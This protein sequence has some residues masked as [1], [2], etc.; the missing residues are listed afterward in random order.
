MT[1]TRSLAPLAVAVVAIFGG[2][3][4]ADGGTSTVMFQWENYKYPD[5]CLGVGLVEQGQANFVV[6]AVPIPTFTVGRWTYADGSALGH[7]EAPFNTA[8]FRVGSNRIQFQAFNSGGTPWC[9]HNQNNVWLSGLTPQRK[10]LFQVLLDGDDV[11]TEVQLQ[12]SLADIDPDL[13]AKIAAF[14][15]SILDK[16]AEL[17]KLG[18]DAD[19]ASA[20]IARLEALLAALDELLTRGFDQ[21]SVAELDALLADFE[22]LLPGLRDD[23]AAIIEGFKQVIEDLRKE[24]DRISNEFRDWTATL[25][26]YGDAAGGFS[27]SDF[28]SPSG[29]SLPEVEVPDVLDDEPW[30]DE[31][32]V[33]DQYADQ[34]IAA[35]RTKL[36]TNESQVV[37]RAG[38]VAILRAWRDNIRVLDVALR[39]RSIVHQA[40]YGAFLH[41][42]NKVL[43]FVGRFMDRDGWFHDAPVDPEIRQLIDTALRQRDAPRAERIK[44]A[45]N[46][47]TALDGTQ[48]SV[49]FGWLF[50]LKE[51]GIAAEQAR[52]ERLRNELA[53][54]EEGLWSSAVGFLERAASIGWDLAVTLTPLGDLIDVCEMLTGKEGCRLISGRDLTWKERA[55]AGVGIVMWGSSSALRKL[56]NKADAIK[57]RPRAMIGVIYALKCDADVFMAKLDEAMKNVQH[58]RPVKEHTKSAKRNE[59]GSWT[60]THNDGTVLNYNARGFPVFESRH[61]NQSLA[62]P[63]VWVEFTCH[64]RGEMD[65]ANAALGLT[66]DPPDHTW[67]HSHEFERR[68]DGKVYILMQSVK[69][70]VH[71]WGLHAGGSAIGRQILGASA[72]R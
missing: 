54:K 16:I 55:F 43:A 2:I 63:Q 21:I 58:K 13:A 67:H 14:K 45:L 7:H 22:D 70:E 62:Q 41:S 57:C 69:K 27:D 36:N 47:M 46:V 49:V 32:D 38:F 65:R 42:Q 19:R 61:L 52:I 59:D 40:E 30:S 51:L 39:S 28:E 10:L 37:D 6:N 9:N 68:S 17:V 23:L 5:S 29:E 31:N 64:S 71:K 4:P 50:V 53:A 72:C 66:K 15:Q 33:Y 1:W 11:D 18:P 3:R 56:G 44:A 26:D 20:D 8:L 60:Y 48:A 25:T 24:L 35:L 12:T 34:V